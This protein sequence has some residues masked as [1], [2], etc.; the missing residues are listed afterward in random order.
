MLRQLRRVVLGVVLTAVAGSAVGQEADIVIPR[1]RSTPPVVMYAKPPEWYVQAISRKVQERWE[2]L[3]VTVVVEIT[4]D[5]RL[6]AVDV[7]RKSGE[8][9]F[10]AA[11]LRVVSTSAPF[12][13]LPESYEAQRV[14]FTVEFKP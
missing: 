7:E 6:H 13:P 2:S 5:G 4:R 10:D 9:A 3:A 1:K 12:P 11:V 14:R 8:A